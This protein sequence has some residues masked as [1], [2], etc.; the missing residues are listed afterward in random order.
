MYQ[1]NSDRGD[2]IRAEFER[3]L[4]KHPEA[5]AL[6]RH[7]HSKS[8][9]TLETLMLMLIDAY[10][11]IETMKC[12]IRALDAIAPKKIAF[13]GRVFIWRCPDSDIPLKTIQK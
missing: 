11:K 1:P 2:L 4:K 3:L 9:T 13:D 6:R 7:C 12:E 5:E 10:A 8:D